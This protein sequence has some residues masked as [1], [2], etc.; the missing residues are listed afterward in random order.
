MSHLSHLPNQRKVKSMKAIV[1]VGV[2]RSRSSLKELHAPHANAKNLV[3]Q[4]DS[5][6]HIHNEIWMLY[7]QFPYIKKTENIHAPLQKRQNWGNNKKSSLVEIQSS[8]KKAE[9]GKYNK[10]ISRYKAIFS[11]RSIIC[12][13]R[14][15]EQATKS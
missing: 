15:L 13:C 3:H 12:R 2:T 10:L 7:S 1:Q 9:P 6:V 4:W 11:N 5:L 14:Q 8:F